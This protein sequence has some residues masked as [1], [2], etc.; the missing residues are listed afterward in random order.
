MDRSQIVILITLVIAIALSWRTVQASIR[1]DRIYGGQFAKIFHYIG[2][3]A[4]LGVLPSALLGTIFVGPLRLGIPLALTYLLIALV[5]LF[6]YAVG[7]R[8]ARA[9]VVLDERGWTEQDAR[10]SGL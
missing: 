4:Y 10:S 3:T 5:A 2:V 7:E 1:R 8:G 9:S 6:L